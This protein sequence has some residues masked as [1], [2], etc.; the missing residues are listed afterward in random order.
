MKVSNRR[1][2]MLILTIALVGCSTAQIEEEIVII[3]PVPAE[4][5]FKSPNL[6]CDVAAKAI[7]DGI[8]GTG[9]AID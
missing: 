9:C 8:G 3:K 4:P 5:V 6:D 1:I 2:P 7:D